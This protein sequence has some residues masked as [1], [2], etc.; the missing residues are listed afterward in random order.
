MYVYVFFMRLCIRYVYCMQLCMY[1]LCAF[2][3]CFMYI[4]NILNMRMCLNVLL[5]YMLCMCLC[6]CM[7]FYIRDAY[8]M[9]CLCI[10][11]CVSCIRYV[12]CMYFLCVFFVID[13]CLCILHAFMYSLCILHAVVYVWSMCVS[14]IIYVNFK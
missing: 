5:M 9:Q 12:Y 10:R 4:W 8:E 3:V 14:C 2:H 6:N 1:G 7:C 13:V 11:V